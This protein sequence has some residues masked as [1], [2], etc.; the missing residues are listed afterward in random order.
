[1]TSARASKLI[2]A[3]EKARPEADCALN[4]RKPFELV[5]ATI[6][7]AQCTDVRVNRVTPALFERYPD[8]RALAGA[9][10]NELEEQIRSTGFFRSK[11]RNLL[12]CATTLVD[13]HGGVVPS[14][15]AE[16]VKLPGVGRKTAN[17]VLGHAF[18]RAE[19]IAVDTHVLRVASRLGLAQAVR[20]PQV[21]AE[22]MQLLPRE[23][24]TRTTD[25]LIFH[26]RK[27]CAARKPACSSC[28]LFPDCRW[29]ER[30]E[31]AAKI[32]PER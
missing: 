15:L 6:L 29:E 10:L 24:W 12:S 8:P 20:A 23:R 17:V 3:L 22:L 19:G 30:L 5:I 21:E 11:A 16:L 18:G 2:D 31:R 26:G 9:E 14:T 28:T 27:V 25:V 13:K 4:F 32:K 7:S 1:M